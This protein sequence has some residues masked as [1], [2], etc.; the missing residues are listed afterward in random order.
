MIDY[1]LAKQLKEAGFPQGM[2]DYLV[3]NKD[4][5]K[6]RS[7]RITEERGYENLLAVGYDLIFIPTLS[8]LIEACGDRF[9]QLFR[10]DN[11]KELQ[12]KWGAVGQLPYYDSNTADTEVF[13][14]DEKTP[15]TAVAKLYLKLNE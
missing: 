14:V 4:E 3:K 9:F 13:R 8:E 5:K 6:H 2:G 7:F 10:W 11:D 1:K 15:E 12:G